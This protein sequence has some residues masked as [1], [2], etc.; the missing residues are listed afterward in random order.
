VVVSKWCLLLLLGSS[1]LFSVCRSG[2]AGSDL[3]I[4]YYLIA[5]KALILLAWY[6]YAVVL[7]LLWLAFAVYSTWLPPYILDIERIA[8]SNKQ[9]GTTHDYWTYVCGGRTKAEPRAL[10]VYVGST[11]PMVCWW[12]LNF[13]SDWMWVVPTEMLDLTLFS[14]FYLAGYLDAAA[15]WYVMYSISLC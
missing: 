7:V 11:T 4:A 2:C 6:G 12:W 10:M 8:W 5:N 13:V 9:S 1:Q 14:L 3:S 15:C